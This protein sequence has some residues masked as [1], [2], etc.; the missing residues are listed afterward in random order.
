MRSHLLGRMTVVTTD[1]GYKVFTPFH[2]RGRVFYNH[3]RRRIMTRRHYHHYSKNHFT[4]ILFHLR[5]YK[6][7]LCSFS[8]SL[9]SFAYAG[10]CTSSSS[11]RLSGGG[12]AVAALRTYWPALRLRGNPC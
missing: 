11:G 3:T 6:I 8:A 9:Q 7:L 1:G 5:A 10:S 2:H 12:C 4:H